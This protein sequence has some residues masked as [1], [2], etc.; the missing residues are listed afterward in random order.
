MEDRISEHMSFWGTN[1]IQIVVTSAKNHPGQLFRAVDQ[2]ASMFLSPKCIRIHLRTPEFQWL[3]ML[4]KRTILHFA[5]S[6][7]MTATNSTALWR[8]ALWRRAL[9]RRALW[10][11]ALWRH[12]L[13]RHALWRHAHWFYCLLSV[14][15]PR[16][17]GATSKIVLFFGNEDLVGSREPELK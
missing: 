3:L 15:R 6:C 16:A 7:S 14:R 2:T 5:F 12:A 9:W 10:R 17:T 1:H 13:W 4:R 11:H 8:H